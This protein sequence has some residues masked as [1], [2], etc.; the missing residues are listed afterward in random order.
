VGKPSEL[1]VPIALIVPLAE[2]RNDWLVQRTLAAR[3]HADRKRV[4]NMLRRDDGTQ[5]HARNGTNRCNQLGLRAK[6][7]RGESSCYLRKFRP[8]RFEPRLMSRVGTR[9]RFGKAT[10]RINGIGLRWQNWWESPGD[11]G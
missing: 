10:A 8:L 1:K 9:E 7:F 11:K 5:W 2:Q 4:P 6:Y 3:L